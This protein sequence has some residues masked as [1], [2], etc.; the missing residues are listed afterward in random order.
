MK[1]GPAP[2]RQC[3]GSNETHGQPNQSNQSSQP[4][5]GATGPGTRSSAPST[6]ESEAG[7]SMSSIKIAADTSSSSHSLPDPTMRQTHLFFISSRDQDVISASHNYRLAQESIIKNGVDESTVFFKNDGT[8]FTDVQMFQWLRK[9]YFKHRGW[10][11]FWIWQFSH[12]EFYKARKGNYDYVIPDKMDFPPD[13]DTRKQVMY[14]YKPK[15]AECKDPPILPDQFRHS[16]NNCMKRKG[17]KGTG[18]FDW[19]L[20]KKFRCLVSGSWTLT[21]SQGKIQFKMHE[22]PVTAPRRTQMQCFPGDFDI[23]KQIPKRNLQIDTSTVSPDHFWAIYA[24]EQISGIYVFVWSVLFNSWALIFAFIWLFVLKHDAD[25]NGAFTLF[26]ISL[27]LN[28]ALFASISQKRH[29]GGN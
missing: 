12:C 17:S 16:F 1:T 18:F 13:E 21:V 14:E 2:A 7:N 27:P 22:L 10:K 5:M 6:P 3:Q 20:I 19:K 11:R 23:I 24:R 9:A 29:Q 26:A 25:L 8:P 15:P 28:V 4:A